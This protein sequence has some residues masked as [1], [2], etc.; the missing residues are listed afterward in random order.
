MAFIVEDGS[1]VANANSYVTV[2]Y[3]DAY[4]AANIHVFATWDALLDADKENLLVWATRELDNR[5]RWKGTKTDPDS[6]LRWPRTGVYDRDNNLIPDDEI[7]KQLMD[8]VCE[9]ARFFMASDRTAD[10]GKEGLK[11]LQVDVIRLEFDEYFK[12]QTLPDEIGFILSGLG[13]IYGGGVRF[14]RIVRS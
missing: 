8:A 6:A 5:V 4:L 10:T 3:A 9:L 1:V 2:A 12:T 7:P 11:V 13:Y 14:P